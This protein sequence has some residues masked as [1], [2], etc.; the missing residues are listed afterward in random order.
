LINHDSGDTTVIN[1]EGPPI[2]AEDWAGFAAHVRTVA[3]SMRA[4]AFSGSLP[5]GI[6]PETLGRLARSL[7]A[8]GRLIYVDTSKAALS[9]VLAQPAG[10]CVK[11]NQHELAAGLDLPAGELSTEQLLAAGQTLLQR[12]AALVVVTLG[13]AG[14][15]AIAPEG[16][17]Q[18][19]PP[20][21]QIVS[22]VGSGDSMLAGLAVA[23]L[24]GKG[25]ANALAFGVA[26]GSANTLSGMPGHFERNV[27]EALL[28]QI[29]VKKL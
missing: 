15:L 8:D 21:V 29:G 2:A 6:D 5:R 13:G 9:A 4:A 14:A 25:V 16:A 23:Q 1:E 19:S 27:V 20:P 10:L 7:A 24:E 18:A 28:G 11:I 12:R 3:E 17:W 26:C 22:T